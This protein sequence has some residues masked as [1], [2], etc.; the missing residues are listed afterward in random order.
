[1]SD[2]DKKQATAE[3]EQKLED[4][5][6]EVAAEAAARA[7]SAE[8][9]AEAEPANAD[10]PQAISAD[11]PVPAEGPANDSAGIS[12]GNPAYDPAIG[13][14]PTEAA[15]PPG[16]APEPAMGKAAAAA[17]RVGG[18]PPSQ[19]SGGSKLKPGVFDVRLPEVFKS[20]VVEVLA[21][22]A[23][24]C[25]QE[26]CRRNEIA[27][28]R[29][30]NGQGAQLEGNLLLDLGALIWEA[31]VLLLAPTTLILQRLFGAWSP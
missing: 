17:K 3:Y 9:A 4:E 15:N 16:V 12:V 6:A 25:F 13:E 5:R 22:G 7:R 14:P 11:Q 2:K 18:E 24:P 23:Q 19:K 26:T 20:K 1:M 21:H 27:Y 31:S 29:I 30:R 10:S 28:V 8:P